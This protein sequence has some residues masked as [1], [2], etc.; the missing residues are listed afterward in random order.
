MLKS[1]QRNKTKGQ[2]DH[3]SALLITTNNRKIK[4]SSNRRV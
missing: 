2:T 4:V 1:V 3:I